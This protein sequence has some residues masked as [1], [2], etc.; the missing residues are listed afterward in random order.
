MLLLPPKFRRLKSQAGSQ[1]GHRFPEF[2]KETSRLGFALFANLVG[3][4]FRLRFAAG[5]RLTLWL[6]LWF[7]FWL[8]LLTVL[9]LVTVF[10]TAATL[11][12]ALPL[13][14]LLFF[15]LVRNAERDSQGLVQIDC[16]GPLHHNC[17]GPEVNGMAA[18][19]ALFSSHNF[20]P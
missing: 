6:T 10:L 15:R 7:T 8:A 12:L 16:T 14:L 13:L 18:T 4:A 20:P 9:F 17:H 11:L 5:L 1:S 2:R 19:L 3:F